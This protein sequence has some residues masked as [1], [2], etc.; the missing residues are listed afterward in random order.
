MAAAN[1]QF[2]NSGDDKLVYLPVKAA[3]IIY[4]ETPVGRDGS[5]A[6]R[7][8]V[9]GDV[10]AGWNNKGNLNNSAGLVGA[11]TAGLLETISLSLPRRLDV[12]RQGHGARELDHVLGR[13]G[14]RGR[15]RGQ[16][17]ARP[18]RGRHHGRPRDVHRGAA[19][20]RSRQARPRRRPPLPG[21]EHKSCAN[22]Q[23]YA[24]AWRERVM[25]MVNRPMQA[26]AM[27]R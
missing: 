16:L 27:F 20:R 22:C 25:D 13:R 3:S 7:A 4:D 23:K 17:Q 8:L 10:F 1:H 6:V 24:T 12:H 9:A 19:D 21:C 5:G 11:L 2:H 18:A 15:R 26:N 14:R